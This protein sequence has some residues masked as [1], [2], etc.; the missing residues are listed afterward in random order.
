MFYS[1]SLNICRHY[2][3]W[4]KTMILKLKIALSRQHSY[5]KIPCKISAN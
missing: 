4:D 2:M 3:Q 1:Q 5:S